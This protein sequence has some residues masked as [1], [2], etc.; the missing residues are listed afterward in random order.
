MIESQS[1]IENP[2]A[3]AAA[4]ATRAPALSEA[5]AARAAV[6]RDPS[7]AANALEVLFVQAGGGAGE[8]R[9]LCELLA[10]CRRPALRVGAVVPAG[11][12][13]ERLLGAQLAV[14][15]AGAPEALGREIE[16]LRR[17]PGA[18]ELAWLFVF[19]GA[20]PD[21]GLL[22][23]KASEVL[24]GRELGLP[25]LESSVRHALERARLEGDLRAF[26]ARAKLVAAGASAGLWEWT[27]SSDELSVSARWREALGSSE[28]GLARAQRDWIERVSPE[29]RTQLL[30]AIAEHIE[31]RTPCFELEY[32]I[33]H[34]DGSWRWMACRGAAA[35]DGEGRPLRLAGSQVDISERKDFETNLVRRA[36]YDELTG[37]PGRALLLD[38]LSHCMERGRRQGERSFALLFLDID[39]FKEINDALGHQAGDRLLVA[40]ARRLEY[41][42]RPGDTAARLSGDEFAVLLEDLG[43]VGDAV[44]VVERIVKELAAPFGLGDRQAT[45][46]ASIGVA[47]GSLDFERPEDMLRDADQAMYR[48]KRER[49]G[50]YA[51]ALE[52][53]APRAVDRRAALEEDLRAA[54]GKS[55]F[56]LHYQPV[57]R[58]DTG[59][60]AG[61]EALLRWESGARGLLDSA[62]FIEAAQH[63]G[64]LHRLGAWAVRAACQEL[65]LLRRRVS[66]AADLFVSVNVSGSELARPDF[67]GDVARTLAATGLDPAGLA[68]E[69]P[70]AVLARWSE[71]SLQGLGALRQTGV[72][73]HVDDFGRAATPIALFG[74]LPIDTL[75]LAP[76]CLDERDPARAGEPAPLVSALVALAHNLGLAVTAKGVERESQLAHVRALGCEGAQGFLL[77]RPL[78]AEA[79][80]EWVR[81][82]LGSSARPA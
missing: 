62:S 64:L 66:G 50:T 30:A 75:K 78:P 18:R 22:G 71:A 69:I 17:A 20:L 8:E 25:V 59:R 67:A 28:S 55:E 54:F 52:G 74:R 37:L 6:A 40:V 46:S 2:S 16:A 44:R 53:A 11:A 68:L 60:L 58:L 73:L 24:C 23:S 33:R 10:S 45:L 32:R 43:G 47:H 51:L 31:E 21:E 14:V 70:E 81:A 27:L 13:A 38:R 42:V 80:E 34:A 19:D 15:H 49:R 48:A 56:Q 26:R 65:A 79:L 7:A 29:D 5:S 72:K 12:A 9:A 63:S 4:L 82:R 1:A 77:G 57:F 36:L 3:P 39:R 35:W 76:E 41:C 61:F